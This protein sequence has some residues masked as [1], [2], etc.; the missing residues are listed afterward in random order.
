MFVFHYDVPCCIDMF[1]DLDIDYLIS[2]ERSE[3]LNT[4]RVG[5][6]NVPLSARSLCES[7]ASIRIGSF[8]YTLLFVY[9]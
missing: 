8:G 1:L 5:F 7:M 4:I 9:A 2:P 6:T 3:G